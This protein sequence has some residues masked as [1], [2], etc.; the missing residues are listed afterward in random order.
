MPMTSEGKIVLN[1]NFRHA[2]RSWEIELP[3]GLINKGETPE[4]AAKREAAEET[5]RSI[6]AIRLLGEIPPDTGVLGIVVPVFIAE[7]IGSGLQEQEDTEAIEDIL[8]LSLDEIK[9]A[10]ADGYYTCKLRGEW[11]KIP[12]RDPF[13]SYALYR[14]L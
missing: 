2:T 12:F 13:L 9:K 8:E 14:I 1:C 11:K 6:G 7:V 10:F 3:R 4:E 5:G